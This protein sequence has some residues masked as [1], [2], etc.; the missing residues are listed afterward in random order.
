MASQIIQG[1]F[2]ERNAAPATKVRPASIPDPEV[3]TERDWVAVQI[4]P[5][6]TGGMAVLEELRGWWV[7]NAYVHC[8]TPFRTRILAND[9]RNGGFVSAFDNSEWPTS[10]V[11]KEQ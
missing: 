7:G 3:V 8:Q 11:T 1:G 4:G 6:A 9:P 5:S 2:A 10:G